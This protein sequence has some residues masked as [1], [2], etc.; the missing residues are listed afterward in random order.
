MPGGLYR[1]PVDPD[2]NHDV[3]GIEYRSH[4]PVA[5]LITSARNPAPRPYRIQRRAELWDAQV[6]LERKGGVL[7][8]AD[9]SLAEK[10]LELF[11]LRHAAAAWLA[12]PSN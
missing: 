2:P 3:F 8:L 1:L 6:A 11:E 5:V 7:S 12:A 10:R 9:Q 4:Q